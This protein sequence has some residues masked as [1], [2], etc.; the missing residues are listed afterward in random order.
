MSPDSRR[1]RNLKVGDGKG[2]PPLSTSPGGP[3][4]QAGAATWCNPQRLPRSKPPKKA[5]PA[6]ETFPVSVALD[7][8]SEA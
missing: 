2:Q 6:S 8:S 7:S 5:A 3:S 1:A 4:G